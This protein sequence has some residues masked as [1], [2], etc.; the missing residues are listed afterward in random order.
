MGQGAEALL[1]AAPAREELTIPV[2]MSMHSG[3]FHDRR[4]KRHQV[5][6]VHDNVPRILWN[7]VKVGRDS[8]HLVVVESSLPLLY[9][10]RLAEQSVFTRAEL[11]EKRIGVFLP[12]PEDA[13]YVAHV[14]NRN[15]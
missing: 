2:G 5:R 14:V 8:G 15:C 12:T 11:I 7:N 4:A 10:E 13:T 9:T 3:P 1:D 6:G